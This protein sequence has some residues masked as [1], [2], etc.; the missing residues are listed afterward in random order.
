MSTPQMTTVDVLRQAVAETLSIDA[1]SLQAAIGQ[2]VVATSAE[3]CPD[4][5]PDVRSLSDPQTRTTVLLADRILA[6]QEAQALAAEIERHHGRQAAQTVLGERA[7]ELLGGDGNVSNH[8]DPNKTYETGSDDTF[9]NSQVIREGERFNVR[10]F[11]ADGDRR[12]DREGSVGDEA[13]AIALA[14]IAVSRSSGRVVPAV[15]AIEALAL[16]CLAKDAAQSAGRFTELVGMSPDRFAA[17]VE[18]GH[19]R[20]LVEKLAARFSGPAGVSML[21]DLK[22]LADSFSDQANAGKLKLLIPNRFQVFKVSLCGNQIRRDYTTGLTLDETRAYPLGKQSDANGDF[23]WGYSL[24]DDYPKGRAPQ[25]N[26]S[27]D[28]R[29]DLTVTVKPVSDHDSGPSM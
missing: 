2:L 18:G 7:N 19:S 4:S 24:T 17:E 21:D 26:M 12:A 6:G 15:S 10:V 22:V 14:D 13:L 5:G 8:R 20:K 9:W 28:R 25:H 29:S 11:D 23:M 1:Q 16:R 27:S 3:C